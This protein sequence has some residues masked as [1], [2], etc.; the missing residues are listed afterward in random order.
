MQPTT[1]R[2]V[3]KWSFSSF[4]I[5]GVVLLRI[6]F[7]AHLIKDDLPVKKTCCVKGTAQSEILT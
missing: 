2:G 5:S 4:H 1:G 7:F 6:I 3:Q